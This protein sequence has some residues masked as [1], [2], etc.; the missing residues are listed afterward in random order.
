MA[1]VMDG[2]GTPIP[3]QRRERGYNTCTPALMLRRAGP[4]AV[5]ADRPPPQKGISH[6]S[7]S[8]LLA[9]EADHP[10]SARSID[11][12]DDISLRSRPRQQ[13]KH[14]A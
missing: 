14:A 8:S 10:P 5:E 3:P 2:Y 7:G 13:S 11:G 6:T 12:L 4:A 1:S 9:V